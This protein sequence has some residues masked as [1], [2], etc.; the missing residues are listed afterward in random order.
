[1]ATQY[2]TT[3]SLAGAVSQDPDEIDT[4]VTVDGGVTATPELTSPTQGG[5]VT[6]PNMG[7]AGAN[8]IIDD[9]TYADDDDGSIGSAS[10][11]APGMGFPADGFRNEKKVA[12]S[13]GGTD[14][15]GTQAQGTLTIDTKPIEGDT[16]TI[17]SVVYTF[18]DT[19]ADAYDVFI[20]ATL[21]TAQANLV[22]AI[23]G[24]GTVGTT[25]YAGTARHTG[26][27][28]ADFSSDDAVITARVPG[29]AGDAIAT[30][31][32]FTA[33]TNVFDA[34]TLGATNP[35]LAGVNPRTSLEPIGISADVA[36][37]DQNA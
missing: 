25:V 12:M 13:M 5:T 16:L 2:A 22:S 19:I 9:A 26:V 37:V 33:G 4:N 35:G 36:L 27:D 30:T 34:T 32:T 10:A 21:A 1:M 14:P 18:M 3:V 8:A 17:G 20:G 15:A 7:F 28:I 29:T 24:T 6:L 31:E 11:F 23:M